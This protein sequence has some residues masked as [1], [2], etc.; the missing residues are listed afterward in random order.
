MIFILSPCSEQQVE[1]PMSNE[2]VKIS[3]DEALLEES[4]MW[5][6]RYRLE[7]GKYSFNILEQDLKLCLQGVLSIS[8]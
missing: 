4:I 8:T 2:G 5:Y 6:G 7:G 1:P 3:E